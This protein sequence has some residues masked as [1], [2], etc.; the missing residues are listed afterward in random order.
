MAIKIIDLEDA[1]DEIEDIQQEISMLSQCETPHV[2]K[3]F[4][5]YLKG[6]KLWII[7]EFLAGGSILDLVGHYPLFKNEKERRTTSFFL[8]SFIHSHPL[9]ETFPPKIDEAR[10]VGWAALCDCHPRAAKSSGIPSRGGENPPRY[11]RLERAPLLSSLLC[12][13]SI[14]RSNIELLLQPPLKLPIYCSLPMETS[15]WLILEL[16]ANLPIRE[17]KETRSLA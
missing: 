11:Q 1:E 7:M 16:Q 10:P 6:Q 8:S 17:Q 14:E 4:G 13:H 9:S 15:S 12:L 2:T 5:S 3:Y